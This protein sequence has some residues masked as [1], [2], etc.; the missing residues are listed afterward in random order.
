[1]QHWPCT[2]PHGACSVEPLLRAAALAGRLSGTAT[3][4][5]LA[6]AAAIGPVC[7][8]T[9]GRRAAATGHALVVVEE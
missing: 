7:L 9:A 1:M 6:K 8:A 5:I 2:G 4:D 3:C